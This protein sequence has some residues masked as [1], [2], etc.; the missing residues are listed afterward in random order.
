MIKIYD[1][2]ELELTEYNKFKI[3]VNTTILF[4]IRNIYCSM[5]LKQA[6]SKAEVL[7]EVFGGVIFCLKRLLNIH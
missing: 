2:M 6:A 4:E 5:L 1:S 7:K 3:T